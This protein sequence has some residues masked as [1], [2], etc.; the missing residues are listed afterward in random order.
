MQDIFS[1]L[2]ATGPSEG[3][4]QALGGDQASNLQAALERGEQAP[5][6]Q[7]PATP[8]LRQSRI[9][10]LTSNAGGIAQLTAAGLGDVA[11]SNA[12]RTKPRDPRQFAKDKRNAL[13]IAR[14]IPGADPERV[15]AIQQQIA[16]VK[17]DDELTEIYASFPVGLGAKGE[18]IEEE[19][20]RSLVD[21]GMGQLE[22][23]EAISGAKAKPEKPG[24]A[25]Q[26]QL[27]IEKMRREAKGDLTPGEKRKF[28]LDVRDQ[29]KKEPAVADYQGA[30]S[31]YTAVKVGAGRGDSQGDLALLNGI[32]RL[33]DPGSVV[34]PSEFEAARAA[35]GLIDQ[36][37]SLI[38]RVTEGDLL[39]DETRKRYLALANQ[40]IGEY[41]GKAKGVVDQL[42]SGVLQETGLTVDDVFIQPITPDG[43]RANTS[44]LERVQELPGQV[45]APISPQAASQAQGAISGASQ[46]LA[47]PT[48]SPEAAS[49]ESSPSAPPAFRIKGIR[50]K[51]Q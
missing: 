30:L 3:A 48:P 34:R 28:Q 9:G 43:D 33:L 25:E 32:T 27:K 17:T 20:Y 8:Q 38:G 6:P 40:L 51:E 18:G 37:G 2:N 19:I 49:P 41:G 22:A 44:L 47:A 21:Q 42:Y 31:G 12:S 13:E 29:V 45:V 14:G 15:K 7:G 4:V 16:S 36:V 10:E 35:Q 50:V 39:G 23:L 46:F 5:L 1:Q 11:K 26:R 24:E